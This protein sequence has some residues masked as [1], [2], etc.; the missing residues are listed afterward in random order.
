MFFY[1]DNI[2]H[3]LIFLRQWQA[4]V[5]RDLWCDK[6]NKLIVV[7]FM[8]SELCE[9]TVCQG[10]VDSNLRSHVKFSYPQLSESI[11]LSVLHYIFINLFYISVYSKWLN[12]V[13]CPLLNLNN[14]SSQRKN[15]HYSIANL[16]III[17]KCIV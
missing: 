14:Q 5:L 10:T 3:L 12:T 8:S 2:L 15:K 13:W 6:N 9:E 7:L 1:W 17:I 11:A 16:N 4:C